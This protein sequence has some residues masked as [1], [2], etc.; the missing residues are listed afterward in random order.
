MKKLIIICMLGAMAAVSVF[1]QLN[2]GAYTKSYWIPYRLT[3]FEDGETK[4]TTA[5][6][7]PWGEPDISAG[8]NFDGWSEWGGLHLGIDVAY[9]AGNVAANP[10]SAKGSGW[11][12]VKPLN[13]ISIMESFTIYLG[14]PN[15]S[16]L[17]GKIGGSNFATYV[18]NNSYYII[19][20]GD[21]RS[22]RLE[23]QNPEYNTFTKFNPY[24]WGNSNQA[25]YD[26][27]LQNLWWPRI[28]AAA[29]VT[30][31]P[32]ERLFI[33]FFVAPEMRELLNWDGKIGDVTWGNT[34]PINGDQLR[35]DDINQDYYDA[36]KVYRKM[37]IGAGYTIPGI[38]FARAQY[39]GA[40]NVVEGAFQ[41]TALGDLI[42]DIG[43]KIPF[44]SEGTDKNDI[45]YKQRRDFQASVAATYRDYDFRLL[46]R[47]DAAFA[48]SDSSGREIKTR[49][50][51][52]IVYLVPS[53]DLSVGTVGLDLGFEYEQ[54]DDFN[55][56]EED[57]MQAGMGLWFQRNLG[58]AT[59]KTG[60]IARLP[61]SWHGTQL[62]FDFFFP[63]ML[64]V[65]F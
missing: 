60:L 36:A 49:G 22:F 45:S 38:G 53:Y 9:G 48:G 40:R 30:W 32:V 27:K 20:Q 58:N 41:L 50:L 19:S 44:E 24:S 26:G 57:A 2:V 52:M 62:P 14:N 42:L 51:N 56:W 29:L 6:Q 28:A 4:S 34:T 10:L 11:V 37:Q 25:T 21:Q 12:W 3:A 43:F 17:M 7:V 35:D 39:I 18:L 1:A 16:T 8:I 65:G 23:I 64:E 54:K 31:E 13:F 46:G 63:I 15:N 5:V 55:G 47:I 59:F 61:L 33:G